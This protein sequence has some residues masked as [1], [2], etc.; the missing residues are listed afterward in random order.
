MLRTK[1]SQSCS[2]WQ[3]L[4]PSGSVLS[5]KR[6]IRYNTEF[7]VFKLPDT[8]LE[9]LLLLITDLP[10]SSISPLVDH[11]VSMIFV[12]QRECHFLLSPM[13]VTWR[14]MIPSH[15]RG[16]LA[17]HWCCANGRKRIFLPAPLPRPSLT[18]LLWLHA[19]KLDAE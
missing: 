16:S 3:R 10:P 17:L 5:E 12:L 2:P 11:G 7:D 1:W 18:H 6:H 15:F 4:A 13:R 14:M 9:F 19:V 8:H